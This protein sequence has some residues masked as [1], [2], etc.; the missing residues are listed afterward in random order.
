MELALLRLLSK[1]DADALATEI[2]NLKRFLFKQSGEID[3][4]SSSSGGGVSGIENVDS[5]LEQLSQREKQS[6]EDRIS[7]ATN[8]FVEMAVLDVGG[9]KE[10]TLNALKKFQTDLNNM[11]VE[12][13]PLQLLNETRK[14]SMDRDDN[15]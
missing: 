14:D 5:F 7:I 9:D 4:G 8:T 1:I 6:K 3:S 10:E 13:E 2:L 12:S 11:V 15:T